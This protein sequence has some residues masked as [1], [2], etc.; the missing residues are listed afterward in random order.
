M[1]HGPENPTPTAVAL[2]QLALRRPA[3]I[4]TVHAGATPEAAERA[5]H[6]GEIGFLPGERV[7]VVARAWPGGEPMVV[8]VGA[9]RFALRGVEAAC[10]SVEPLPADH[11]P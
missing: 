4:R 6:L 5:R 1:R 10:V 2:H 11:G 8:S 7:S 3:R 9:S